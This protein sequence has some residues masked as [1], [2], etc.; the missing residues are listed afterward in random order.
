MSTQIPDVSPGSGVGGVRLTG[1]SGQEGWGRWTLGQQADLRF[2]LKT[3]QTVRIEVAGYLAQRHQQLKIVLDGQRLG[4]FSYKDSGGNT[5]FGRVSVFGL[6][7]GEH[8]LSFGSNLSSRT[9]KTP[10][11]AP[12][13]ARDLG[14][15]V[16]TL[17]VGPQPSH[18][19]LLKLPADLLRSSAVKKDG[20]YL[21]S[22]RGPYLVTAPSGF[23]TVFH[24]AGQ[25][26]LR[27]GMVRS[28]QNQQFKFI[29]N[30]RTI[31][32]TNVSQYANVVNGTLTLP[33]LKD[34]L[35]RL[36]VES[37]HAGNLRPTPYLL[38]NTA[39]D[40]SSVGFYMDQFQLETTGHPLVWM[41][42]AVLL[43]VLLIW[44]CFRLL[45]S[46]ARSSGAPSIQNPSSH[47]PGA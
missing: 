32:E 33:V 19:P 37:V 44:Q 25:T 46:Q 38:R 17:K 14:V 45:F 1:F 8:I 35:Q 11:F 5:Y 40:D 30:N 23:N 41:T 43:A 12:S 18:S 2:E 34:G 24:S 31:Y 6:A 7:S 47:P 27:D 36:T 15:A 28:R 29:L 20:Y 26:M 22:Q 42:L 39:V 9:A 13:D 16:S 21:L 4:L 10:S 3:A